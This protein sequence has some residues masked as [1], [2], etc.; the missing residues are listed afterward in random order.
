MEKASRS[1]CAV[2]VAVGCAVTATWTTR[3][4]WWAS[5]TSTNKTRPVAVGT[6]K[7]SAAMIWW[8]VI[9]Q[10]RP[11]RLRRWT[12]RVNQIFRDAGL[13]IGRSI[14][15]GWLAVVMLMP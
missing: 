14:I 12:P 10:E 15:T 1:C 9:R 4:R 8:H 5:M 2:Q 13:T 3:R 7:K 11:P 6:T